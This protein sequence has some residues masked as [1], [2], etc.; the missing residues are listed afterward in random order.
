MIGA[1]R[2]RLAPVIVSFAAKGGVSKSTTAIQIA[3]RAA[4]VGGLRVVLVDLSRG[5][6]DVPHY[7]RVGQATLPSLYDAALSG[8]P[9]RAFSAPE[10]I[11]AA[12]KPGLPEVDFAVALA[13]SDTQGDPRFVTSEVYQGV[14]SAARERAD[15]VVVDT[16]IVES[17][18]TSGLI[19]DVV[20]PLLSS[21][22]GWGIGLSDASNAGLQNLVR[23]FRSFDATGV[24]PSR[25]M[26]AFSR[27]PYDSQIDEESVAGVVSRYAHYV[28]MVHVSDEV[29]GAYEVGRFPSDPELD[30][31]VDRVLARVTGIAAFDPDVESG[32]KHSKKRRGGKKPGGGEPKRRGLFRRKG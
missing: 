4:L 17:H 5:Q 10:A 15:L 29:S 26:V 31:V 14:I 6:G 20:T 32:K 27:I 24:G 9:I 7:L 28:G 22:G 8:N 12:R 13:P 18:D 21:V 2:A 11:N 30:V 3:R 16:Q 1:N 25:L 23:R 19:R